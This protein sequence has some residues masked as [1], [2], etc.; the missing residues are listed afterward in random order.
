MPK[1]YSNSDPCIDPICSYNIKMIFFLEKEN[2]FC[3]VNYGCT[4]SQKWPNVLTARN[5]KI[6]HILLFDAF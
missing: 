6:I 2:A 4:L 5:E 3:D 1:T